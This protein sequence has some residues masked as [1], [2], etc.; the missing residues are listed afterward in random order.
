[1]ARKFG[2]NNINADLIVGLPK[3]TMQDV[4]DS[5]SK[6]KQI[7]IKH[8]SVY[9]LKV[10]EGTSLKKGGYAVDEDLA[11]DFYEAAYKE[12]TQNK[13]YNRYEVSNFCLPGFEC[14]HNQKYW[15]MEEYLGLGLAA[16]SFLGKV[17]KT[18]TKDFEKYLRGDFAE[19]S[20]DVNSSYL[21]E[22]I[23]LGLR[24]SDGIDLQ[25][26]KSKNIDLLKKAKMRTFIEKGIVSVQDN[27]LK[28]SDGCFYVMNAIIA[29]II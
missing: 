21:A 5:V 10:E 9:G 26:L 3:Q 15:R 22:Y 17:R 2:I 27:R 13:M 16:S 6:L 7:G 8:I 29:E 18:N 24:T 19:F 28:I 20:E 4:K 12:L 11:A 14:K 1:T 25:F 23:M